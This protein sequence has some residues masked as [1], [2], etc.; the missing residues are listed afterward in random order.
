M[1]NILGEAK[2]DELGKLELQPKSGR[3]GKA[4]PIGIARYMNREPTMLADFFDEILL[5]RI[6]PGRIGIK[7]CKLGHIGL[8]RWWLSSA[9]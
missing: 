9:Q 6:K 7:S 5:V 3:I 8:R 2:H 4:R 1:G